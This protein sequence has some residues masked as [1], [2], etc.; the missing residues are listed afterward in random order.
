MYLQKRLKSLGESVS[1]GPENDGFSNDLQAIFESDI[2]RLSE[3]S[4]PGGVQGLDNM[5]C[6]V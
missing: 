2:A 4:A 1:M 6:K 3:P 5:V